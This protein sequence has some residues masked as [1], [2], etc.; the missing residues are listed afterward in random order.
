MT[1]PL[2]ARLL[3]F[4]LTL[5]TIMGILAIGWMAFPQHDSGALR[6]DGAVMLIAACA[7]YRTFLMDIRSRGGEA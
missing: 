6:K 2:N 5:I 7:L 3:A 1:D 4:A